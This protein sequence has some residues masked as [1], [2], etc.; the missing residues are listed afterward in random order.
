MPVF[1]KQLEKLINKF[2]CKSCYLD[3]I[4]ATVLKDYLQNVVPVIT[5][6]VNMSTT[7]AVVPSSTKNVSCFHILRRQI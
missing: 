5:K 6:I 7:E 1:E 2:A 4:P 3:P